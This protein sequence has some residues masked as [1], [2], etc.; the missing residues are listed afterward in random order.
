MDKLLEVGNFLREGN[1]LLLK[2]FFNFVSSARE[3][4]SREIP[5]ETAINKPEI[6]IAIASITLF[7]LLIVPL[8]TRK[9][10]KNNN[11]ILSYRTDQNIIVKE[12]NKTLHL[13]TNESSHTSVTSEP[14]VNLNSN[15]NSGSISLSTPEKVPLSVNNNTSSQPFPSITTSLEVDDFVRRLRVTGL[16][17][18]RLKNSSSK[19]QIL[20]LTSKAD[21]RWSRSYFSKY[22]PI[23][24]IV[25]AFEA[26]E[27]F[28]LEFKKKTLH[29]RIKSSEH[30]YNATV[31]V[32]YFNLIINK[33]KTHPT[34]VIDI[35]NGNYDDRD[36]SASQ[37]PTS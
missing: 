30:P 26:D 34:F 2:E 1:E 29:F 35:C 5:F 24:T 37:A 15:A 20:Q 28:I 19:D 23:N 18:E 31:V 16:K 11:Q 33:L 17:I 25:S 8:I 36:D 22:Q 3:F 12:E 6:S 7:I 9:S 10:T 32:K 13:A 4:I 21:L 27:G 14:K